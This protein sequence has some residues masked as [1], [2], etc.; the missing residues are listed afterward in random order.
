VT[1]KLQMRRFT[2]CLCWYY[3]QCCSL[4]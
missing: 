4:K 2:C 1:L 3:F